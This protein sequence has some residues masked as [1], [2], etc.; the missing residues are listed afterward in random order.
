MNYTPIYIKTE[1]SLLESLIK[2]QDLMDYAKELGF[3]VLT[4]T[5]NSMFGAMEFYHACKQNDIKPIIGL[6]LYYKDE[7]IVL[8][9]KNYRGYQNLIKLSTITSKQPLVVDDFYKFSGELICLLPFKS[10]KL[11]FEFNKI[12][13]DIY[14]GYETE[15]QY[16]QLNL[17]NTLYMKEIT[18]LKKDDVKYLKYLEAIKKGIL[19]D[20]VITS[21]DDVYLK[22]IEEYLK[23]DYNPKNNY[24]FE[25][26]FNL[27]IPKREDL[28]PVYDTSG[29]DINQYLRKQ[30]KDGLKKRFGEKVPKIY[31][32]RL[33]YE[34]SI[35]EKMG[36]SNYFLVVCDYVSYAKE[37]DILVGPG[38]GSAA[39][40]LVS[41]V[42]NITDIDPIR[43][44]LLFER[45][46]NPERIT[47]PDI[48]IDFL[49]SRRDEVINY[50][51]QKYGIKRAAG[52]ITFGTLAAKQA[53]RD[54]FRTLDVEVETIS[55]MLSSRMTLKENLQNNQNLKKYLNE[56]P[57]Q[58]EGFSI[59]MKLEG[60]KRHTSIHAAGMVISSVDLD[61]VVPL[62][63]HDN[64]YLTSYS[65]NYLEDLGLLKMDFL[66]LKNLN[67][68]DRVLKDLN[69]DNVNIDFNNIP[70]NDKKALQIFYDVN[71]IG[72]FQFES[73][74]MM[75]FLRKFKPKTFEEI[76]ACL[77]LYRPGPMGNIDTYI[78]RKEGKEKVDYYHT[79]L[80]PI[81]KP[82]YG[83]LIYQEQIM[84]VA[85][86]MAS[87]S[88]GEADILRR[89]MSKK[90]EDVLLKGREKFISRAIK[91]GYEE[92]IALEVYELILKFASYGFNKAHS[93][94]YAM[95]SYKMAYLKA[96]YPAY[97]MRGLLDMSIGSSSSTKGYIY[98][99]KK[100]KLGI[101]GP[102]INLSGKN[103]TIC[104]N[105]I[106]YPLYNIKN[107]GLQASELIL[108]E[109]KKGNFKDIYDFVKRTYSKA[110]NTGTLTNLILSGCFDS[111][112]INRKTLI[113]NLELILNYAEVITYLDEEYALKPVLEEMEEFDK[114]TLMEQELEVFGFY[115]STHPVLEFREKY[116]KKIS[117]KDLSVYFDKNIEII[118]S[119]KRLKEIETKKQD[120]MGF[121]TCEDEADILDVVLFPILYKKVFLEINDIILIKGHVEKRF[122]KFQLVASD[123]QKLEE[124]DD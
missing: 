22:K 101:L 4:I 32:D 85:N 10:R 122:D 53:V 44:N 124:K 83:I 78:R 92:K 3:K 31:I 17:D 41:Y 35:I 70:L 39:G 58:K 84:Q 67:I 89:A 112:N 72:I 13:E 108:E 123:I 69:K 73:E 9:A 100:N 46:L 87:Y 66:G 99:A 6:E 12:Y 97:F 117:I 30:C 65:M 93:V 2:I 33:K 14:L 48:D 56:H 119:V 26:K 34:L 68:I 107:V 59:A 57:R 103:Y 21:Y 23:L 82:T 42:L 20:E 50:C 120:K 64:M 54:V 95:I 61:D 7:K 77:A 24:D 49:D 60:L 18:C 76:F 19:E 62:Y 38:R 52:I 11:Y 16:K 86:V 96:H 79:S 102:D 1:N 55:K 114:K 118:A 15:E 37:N 94:A 90:K 121:L 113:N 74:G 91:N 40:S 80:E 115:L 8:Y 27:E 111:F 106:R 109:R 75:N 43:Y 36:F 47:M 63:Y 116:N 5:D 110:M 71:T 45:F 81:L 105:K 88:L 28:L 51:V 25:K 104:D 98:E 29:V